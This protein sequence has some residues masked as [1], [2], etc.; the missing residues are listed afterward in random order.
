MKPRCDNGCHTDTT[1]KCCNGKELCYNCWCGLYAVGKVPNLGRDKD[2]FGSGLKSPNKDI[3][4][5]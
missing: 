3:A 5:E 2:R 1:I 4:L